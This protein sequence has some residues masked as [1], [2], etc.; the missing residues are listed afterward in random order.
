MPR[1]I[2]PDSLGF[3]LN[4]LARLMRSAFEQEI[5]AGAIPVTP[6]EARVLAHMSRC[7]AVQQTRLA[8]SLGVAP[9]SLSI[10]IDR[11]EAAGLVERAPDPADRRAKLVSLTS[12]AGPVLTEI[13]QAGK[14]AR[15]LATEGIDGAD[16]EI[17]GRTA[18]RIRDTLDTA[19]RSRDASDRKQPA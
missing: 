1:T 17:F 15:T 4:D 10:F 13:A 12:A 5:E 3:L 14:R 8:C 7:G 16:L 9:M 2:D 11:L 6:A 18:R 19:R